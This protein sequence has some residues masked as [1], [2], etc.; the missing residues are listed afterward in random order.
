MTTNFTSKNPEVKDYVLGLDLGTNSIGWAMIEWQNDAPSKLFKTGVRIFQE[1]VDAKTRI[2]K[3][4]ARRAARA[5]RRLLARY[6][7]RRD[8]LTK[9]LIL[10]GLLPQ[11]DLARRLLL[12]D[13]KENDPFLLRKKAL[14]QALTLHQLGRAIYHLNQRRGFKSNRKG[15]KDAD[16]GIVKEAISGLTAAI[17]TANARTLGEFLANQDRR[18][19]R[20]P[21]HD[22]Y[23]ERGMYEHEFNEIWN[24]QKEYYPTVLTDSLRAQLYRTIFFQ[25]P[26]KI[27][28]Y[29][30]GYCT[31]EKWKRRCPWAREQAQRFRYMQAVNNLEI[32][33]PI[34]REYRK[35]R[36]DERSKL[37]N[38]LEESDLS[39]TKVRKIL[40]I[41][42]GEKFKLENAN[43]KGLPGNRTAQALVKVL[44]NKF[45]KLNMT[46]RHNLVTDIITIDNPQALLNR[47]KNHW[48]FTDEESTALTNI[49]LAQGY[50][51]LSSKTIGKLMPFLEKGLRYDE[52]VKAAGYSLTG[53]RDEGIQKTRGLPLLTE[54]P[55]VRNPVVQKS[56]YEVR[57]V[58]N[59]II[60]RYGKPRT[61]RVEMARDLKMGPKQLSQYNSDLK[62]RERKN[63][64]ITETLRSEFDLAS[65][66]RHDVE[67]YKLWAEMSGLCPYTG[68]SI[69]AHMLFTSEVEVE[70]IIPFHRS[71]DDSYMNKTISLAS[72]NKQKGN[73]TPHEM[74]VGRSDEY[75]EV[76]RRIEKL[77]AAKAARFEQKEVAIDD[78]IARQLN[79]TR[80]LCTEV[81]EY[82]SCLGVSIQ[83]SKGQL[84]AMLR[85]A[86]GVNNI[87]SLGQGIGKKERTDHRHHAID[88]IVIGLTTPKML[89]VISKAAASRP[90]GINR[91]R[92]SLPEPWAGFR[93]TVETDIKKLIVSH[94]A[95]RKITDALHED[96][97]WG[98]VGESNTFVTSKKLDANITAGQIE[99]IRD[100]IVQS[101]VMKRFAAFGKQSKLAFGNPD[102]PVLHLD[103]KTPIRTVR[104]FSNMNPSSMLGIK[105]RDGKVYKYYALGNNHHVTLFKEPGGKVTPKFASALEAANR[106][107]RQ[108]KVLF[109]RTSLEQSTFKNSLCPNDIVAV[110]D[111]EGR[112]YRVQKMS[113]SGAGFEI[114][115]RDIY[116]SS[117]EK[118]AAA[119]ELRVCGQNM[120]RK[121]T[122]KSIS[123][124][125][126]VL[127]AND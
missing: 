76:L 56:L 43:P 105:D 99:S 51:R 94:A 64:E 122:K 63:Q 13:L 65:P 25:R 30:V 10:K 36:E 74:F 112:F 87:L 78:F 12:T 81:K 47:F 110:D 90:D 38:H 7:M 50:C 17:N 19:N 57:K 89:N 32:I 75:L 54:P 123:I 4:Q 20:F 121:L 22:R 34:L 6:R 126:D 68:K 118:G 46:E 27:Q 62:K 80:Y 28:K 18:R 82:L 116:I 31:F 95:R 66:T 77:P 45:R 21:F 39:W 114:T 86:W 53:N 3:N 106:V 23:T 119:G 104:I 42:Q 5:A 85:R 117:V 37:L 96:T 35:L 115:L 49:E 103:G 55:R 88:A 67:K 113:Q 14:D 61:I 73:L 125:G 79:D 97:A 29:L 8:T 33:D 70:H 107:R 102:Q 98:R 101:L 111:Q 59:A 100:P 71:L 127:P 120:L 69:A 41:H 93:G 2:P 83:V 11:D 91:L 124:L 92:L 40:G 60:K 1:A 26:L 24:K 58:I 44:G 84:T 52:A 9:L 72:A 48:D 15:K 109:D 16:D 108:K